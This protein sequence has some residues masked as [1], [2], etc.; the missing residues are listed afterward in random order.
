MGNL[1]LVAERFQKYSRRPGA[2][3]IVIRRQHI[4]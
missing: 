4:L 3:A 2:V 1:H